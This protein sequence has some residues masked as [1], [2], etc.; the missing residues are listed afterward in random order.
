MKDSLVNNQ[1]GWI[2][3]QK[4]DFSVFLVVFLRFEKEKRG[5]F[6][7]LQ[8]SYTSKSFLYYFPIYA[9]Y[10]ESQKWH[11][12]QKSKQS[13]QTTAAQW[14]DRVTKPLRSLSN[15]E[16]FLDFLNAF[17]YRKI[18]Y[19]CLSYFRTRFTCSKGATIW[20]NCSK[21]RFFMKKM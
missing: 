15:I 12:S 8:Q 17:G 13:F 7:L 16:T 3:Y 18:I 19:P 11:S 20:K 6:K 10:F 21:L 14:S 4:I 5:K 9:H 2:T 1:I